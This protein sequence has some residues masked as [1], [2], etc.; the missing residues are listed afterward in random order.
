MVKV[1]VSIPLRRKDAAPPAHGIPPSKSLAIDHFRCAPVI[2]DTTARLDRIRGKAF[3]HLSVVYGTERI[4]M[5]DRLK[6]QDL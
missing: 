6:R 2:L 3:T 4:A 1:L 5:P